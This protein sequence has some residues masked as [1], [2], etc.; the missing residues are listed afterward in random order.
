MKKLL[1]FLMFFL[2][3]A[4]AVQTQAEDVKFD[5]VTDASS[6]KAGDVLI[7]GC[8]SKNKVAGSLGSS[9]LSSYDATDFFSGSTV[10]IPDN[11]L[12]EISVF[13]LGGSAGAWTLTTSNG[14][15]G[16]T[17]VKKVAW[18]SG[19]TTWSISISNG[20]ATIQNGTSS[21]GKFLY[22]VGSPRF[23]TY[24]SG[25]STSMLLPELYRKQSATPQT[26]ATPTF[27]PAEGTFTK[28]QSVTI[29]CETEGATIH[30]TTDGTTPDAQSNEY[31]S[32]ITVSETTTIKAIAIKDGVSSE[33][34]S[35]TYT[36]EIPKTMTSIAISGT[37]TTTT[38]T[39][40]EA[41]STDGLSVIATY[42]D[43]SN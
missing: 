3:A 15:L 34:A 13:T 17:A 10:S 42:S 22:N 21:Y 41:F 23:T 33:V 24:T 4:I 14:A 2:L 38:Y 39:V 12:S 37:P 43:N 27:S 32:A 18:G 31:S 25:A 16:A 30:Y 20:L 6:L 35:A 5:L 7:I 1:T 28:A 29:S 40:G 19:T 26:V 9:I 8:S 36:I 11:A